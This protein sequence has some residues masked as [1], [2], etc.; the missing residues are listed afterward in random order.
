MASPSAEVRR[1]ERASSSSVLMSPPSS[2]GISRKRSH[3]AAKKS[4][5]DPSSGSTCSASSKSASDRFIPTRSAMNLELV[6]C[7]SPDTV[8]AIEAASNRNKN[9]PSQSGG[10]F[11][12]AEDEEKQIYKKRLAS[13]LL[14]KEDDSKHKILK[15]TKAK[16]AVAPPDSFKSTLQARFSHNKVSVVPAAAAKKLNR[17]VPSAP[18]KCVYLWNAASGE[19]SELMGLD[20]DEYVSSVQWSD[21][22]GGSAHLAI[23][24]SESVVQLWD[25]AAS[26]QVRTMNGHSSRVGALAWNSYVLSSGSR[27]STII[28]HD[29]RARQHQLSTLTSHEQ[30]VCGL[31]WSP[32]GTTLASGGNDNAL[33][34]WKAGSIG[35]SRSMQAPTHRLE[36]HTAAVKAIAWCPWERNLL[37]TGGGTADRTIKFWNTTNG[38]LLNS[39]DT[40]SQVCS[41]LWSATEKELLSS[42]GYSQ[43]ELCLWKYPS[44][45]KVKEL[46]GHTSRVLHLAASPD[47]ETV[48]SGAAD[49]T[50]RFW[51]VFGPNR[52]ARKAGSAT[53]EL[54]SS[55]L[56]SVMSI[57]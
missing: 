21:A 45:T 37:A 16:P 35:T 30:E 22:A 42:H 41:L 52:K 15:F 26:R 47:G 5:T 23:G 43:N 10:G 55:S 50:L 36:Q 2:R 24:T 13:A 28:H 11:N 19:I 12:A 4:R 33:C 53:A 29:V 14:G 8:A 38:A 44:M 20:G 17:H 39:V 18:I 54:T 57:R 56:S 1:L 7:N 25:V 51:K 27:D 9:S 49:E 32:D 46:T 3:N 31:Q 40:G 6:Q 48:V 34:L